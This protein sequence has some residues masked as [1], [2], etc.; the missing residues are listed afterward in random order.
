M[1]GI[2][3]ETEPVGGVFS[4][5]CPPTESAFAKA[6]PLRLPLKGGVDL[7]FSSVESDLR[8]GR[9]PDFS[10]GP[11]RRGCLSY[12]G[13]LTLPLR[14]GQTLDTV[15][16]G[17]LRVRKEALV[18]C[19]KVVIPAKAGIHFDFSPGGAATT[20]LSRG[21]WMRNAEDSPFVFVFDSAPLRLGVKTSERGGEKAKAKMDSAF[22]GMTA[23]GGFGTLYS[24]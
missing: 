2:L 3:P 6:R 11:L 23:K 21:V 10:T 12:R 9:I 1:R 19:H 24:P 5:A 8:W 20:L 18:V 7:K 13:C 16:A 4:G 17:Q 15:L 22:A 14:S